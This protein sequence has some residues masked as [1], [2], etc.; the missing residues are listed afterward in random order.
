MMIRYKFKL[1]FCAL[2]LVS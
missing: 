1:Q 2:W